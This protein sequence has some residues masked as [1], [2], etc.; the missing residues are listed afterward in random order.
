MATAKIVSRIPDRFR[1][2]LNKNPHCRTLRLAIVDALLEDG[3]EVGADGMRL[4]VDWLVV[5]E[6]VGGWFVTEVY[7]FCYDTLGVDWWRGV[8]VRKFG[9]QP[10]DTF[11]RLLF[12]WCELFEWERNLIKER[13]R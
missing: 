11:D 9:D 3:D 8:P 4:L 5:A 6:G 7:R 10:S 2:T 1:A 13:K 12:G